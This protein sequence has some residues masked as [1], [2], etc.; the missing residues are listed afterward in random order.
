MS[1]FAGLLSLL[2]GGLSNIFS[3]GSWS[4]LGSILGN[5]GE[6]ANDIGNQN[7]AGNYLAKSTGSR[8]TDAEREAN[9]WTA[10]REDIAWERQMEASNTAYQRQVADM[11]A[12]GLNPAMLYGSGSSGASVPSASTSGSVSPAG[13]GFNLGQLLQ[14]AIEYKL[15]PAKLAN[16]NAD[17]AKKVADAD[18]TNIQSGYFKSVATIRAE[19]ERLENEMK[20]SQIRALD[21][22]IRHEKAKIAQTIENTHESEKRQELILQQS[23]LANVQAGNIKYMQPFLARESVSRAGLN[24]AQSKLAAVDEAYKQGLIDEDAISAAVRLDNANASEKEI[25]AKV[26]EFKQSIADGSLADGK[27]GS[28]RLVT[29]LYTGLDNLSKSI[30][31]KW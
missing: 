9:A 14:M 3:N 12:A 16:I 18:S 28:E 30:L 21:T 27:T 2:T 6:T 22:S 13:A 8:L 7:L 19:A 5:A 1:F 23:I 24:V 29:S 4:N 11:Q 10:Q 20:G 26:A 17:T 25:A 31:G 15:L